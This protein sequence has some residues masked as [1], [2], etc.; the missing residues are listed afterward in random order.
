MRGGLAILLTLAMLASALLA[1]SSP[2][3]RGL[4]Y[5][6]LVEVVFVVDP[7][8][9]GEIAW[10]VYRE[11]QDYW[12]AVYPLSTSLRYWSQF[13]EMGSILYLEARPY[14][15]HELAA[16]EIT[17][18]DAVLS[19]PSP[20][21]AEV[22]LM[23]LNGTIIVHAKFYRLPSGSCPYVW[24]PWAPAYRV[25]RA[26]LAALL[27]L[28]IA[29]GGG[30]ALLLRVRAARRARRALMEKVAV[31]ARKVAE[32][33]R[34]FYQPATYG[35]KTPTHLLLRLSAEAPIDLKQAAQRAYQM[36][37][38]ARAADVRFLNIVEEVYREPDPVL[39][40]EI[41]ERARP[42]V[43]QLVKVLLALNDMAPAHGSIWA[44]IE[45]RITSCASPEAA[46]ETIL[47]AIRE[48]SD[49]H[50]EAKR[51]FLDR[52]DEYPELKEVVS[53][54]PPILAHIIDELTRA[55]LKRVEARRVGVEA[56][57][58]GAAPAA[59]AE[60]GLSPDTVRAARRLGIPLRPLMEEAARN[61][62]P[63]PARL[64][65]ELSAAA[66]RLSRSYNAD[67]HAVK[68][69]LRDVI[70]ELRGAALER[71]MDVLRGLPV[72]EDFLRLD[73]GVIS[74]Y[75]IGCNPFKIP[76]AAK[77][78][79][80]SAGLDEALAEVDSTIFEGVEVDEAGRVRIAE[81]ILKAAKLVAEVSEEEVKRAAEEVAEAVMGGKG[82]VSELAGAVARRMR[83]ADWIGLAERIAREA[84]RIVEERE[85]APE[86]IEVTVPLEMCP[87]CGHKLRKTESEVYCEVCKTIYIYPKVRPPAEEGVRFEVVEMDALGPVCPFCGSRLQEASEGRL[88]S[89]CNKIFR[90]RRMPAEIAS[91]SLVL[92]LRG[93]REDVVQIIEL[94]D[95]EYLLPSKVIEV[96]VVGAE[97]K[98]YTEPKIK[99]LS[100]EGVISRYLSWIEKDVRSGRAL[101]MMAVES[102][103]YGRMKKG[104][105]VILLYINRIAELLRILFTEPNLKALKKKIIV[106]T[107]QSNPFCKPSA[108]LKA[109]LSEY[110]IPYEVVKF[111]IGDERVL[112]SLRSA[113]V[114]RPELIL[115][116]AKAFPRLVG[117]LRGG[118]AIRD[119]IRSELGDEEGLH[120]IADVAQEV[121]NLGRRLT[122]SE[123]LRL[124]GGGRSGRTYFRIELLR[125]LG[126]VE[127]T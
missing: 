81:E 51:A 121:L 25:D 89:K 82:S 107:T 101:I 83:P 10:G 22:A 8:N 2:P 58:E 116:L 91:W 26:I 119:A 48:Y 105:E 96:S 112:E 90:L 63:N 21:R 36:E 100:D 16:L 54:P 108:K 23:P 56:V 1:L 27:G 109:L 77:R 68:L 30:A 39:K 3:C 55:A 110:G 99:G 33:V 118:A 88:C 45:R 93:V 87:R 47:R 127:V 123:V 117:Y 102:G 65:E 29:G 43:V 44:M 103:R 70:A 67:P 85:A 126:L 17:P 125:S 66:E 111:R 41:L 72:P 28:V 94:E 7:P 75:S 122:A 31:D 115:D 14:G 53:S 57:V 74:L 38:L 71:G 13:Y 124:V 32:A 69:L 92:D 60:E 95:Y 73:P 50:Q 79:S 49:L 84:E 42:D 80:P 59:A 18:A 12:P 78:L 19:R 9:S 6:E 113:G 98:I 76:E 86:V 114:A 11:K 64:D 106:I 4:V 40:F 62:F 20:S 35:H 5:T 34:K 52:L 37:A 24:L 97:A 104:E 15:C 46:A 61:L 120:F